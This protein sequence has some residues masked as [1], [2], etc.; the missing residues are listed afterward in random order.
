V[1]LVRTLRA[2]SS[3]GRRG[4][5]EDASPRPRVNDVILGFALRVRAACRRPRSSVDAL[6]LFVDDVRRRRALRTASTA[7]VVLP[8]NLHFAML[9]SFTAKSN[10][11]SKTFVDEPCTC[12]LYK[13]RP[14]LGER[15]AT[16]E[17]CVQATAKALSAEALRRARCPATMS[18]PHRTQRIDAVTHGCTIGLYC[19]AMTA[20]TASARH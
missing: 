18:S 17:R 13:S 9:R 7:V 20:R 11:S 2:R 10:R 8:Q 1:R 6:V 16:C 3:R 12:S 4:T 15:L 19:L 14:D 5:A